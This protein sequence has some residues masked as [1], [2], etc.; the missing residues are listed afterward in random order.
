MDKA[1]IVTCI[2][3]GL[4]PIEITKHKNKRKKTFIKKS[5]ASILWHLQ[6]QQMDNWF[7]KIKKIKCKWTLKYL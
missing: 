1:L 2:T 7:S 6:K 3:A 5:Q 4:F